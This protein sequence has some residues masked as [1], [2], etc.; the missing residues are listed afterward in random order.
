M[1]QP[2]GDQF[3]PSSEIWQTVWLEKVPTNYIEDIKI[4]T[5]LSYINIT[6]SSQSNNG[7]I[8][9]EIIDPTDGNTIYNGVTTINKT[10]N[11][12][13]KSPKLWSPS[14]P[15]LYK[16]QIKYGNDYIESYA[17]M[18]TITIK[19]SL[20]RPFIADAGIEESIGRMNGG[21]KIINGYPNTIQNATDCWL[22]CNQTQNCFIFRRKE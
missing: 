20:K 15:I 5:D 14:T 21:G 13:I 4:S 9:I 8:E 18:R 11:T 17:G 10:L 3:S 2:K 19:P 16:L 7:N 1:T 6:A 22:K 12:S